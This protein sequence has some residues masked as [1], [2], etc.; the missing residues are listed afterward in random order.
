MGTVTFTTL[1]TKSNLYLR[2]VVDYTVTKK[3]R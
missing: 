3:N 1:A 2:G